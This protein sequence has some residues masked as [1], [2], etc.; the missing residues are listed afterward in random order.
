[1]QI[2]ISEGCHMLNKKRDREFKFII[3]RKARENSRKDIPVQS[4]KRQYLLAAILIILTLSSC[5]NTFSIFQS[6]GQEVKQL[7]AELFKGT[8]VRAMG[9][10]ATNYYALMSKVVYKPK[11][12]VNWYVRPIDGDT[13]YFS[14]GLASDGNTIYVAKADLNANLKDIYSIV[15]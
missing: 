6:I 15:Y 7:G 1:M 5:D 10:D 2:T 12:G 14:P 9:S 4:K 3:D 11:S 13:D 8:T